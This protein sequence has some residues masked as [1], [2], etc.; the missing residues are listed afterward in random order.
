MVP[1][2]FKQNYEKMLTHQE[3]SDIYNVSINTISHWV[4]YCGFRRNV[5]YKRHR[6]KPDP[7]REELYFL[8]IEKN[9]SA[10]R[11]GSE[12]NVTASTVSKWLKELNLTNIKKRGTSR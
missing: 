11:I 9:W 10:K 4:K 3:L 1:P 5:E 7:T 6:D 8:Y 12:Y 2:T